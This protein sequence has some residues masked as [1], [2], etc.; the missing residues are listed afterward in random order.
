M[1]DLGECLV[2]DERVEVT[3]WIQLIDNW[4]LRF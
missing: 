3:I 4:L 2:G 1:G